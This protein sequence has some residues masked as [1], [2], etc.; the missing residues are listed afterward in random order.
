MLHLSWSISIIQCWVISIGNILSFILLGKHHF[1]IVLVLCFAKIHHFKFKVSQNHTDSGESCF[2]FLCRFAY[3]SLII[4]HS[5]KMFSAANE[6]RRFQDVF[7][8]CDDKVN[9]SQHMFDHHNKKEAYGTHS[10]NHLCKSAGSIIAV[11]VWSCVKN[12]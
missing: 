5:E 6:S 11:V 10:H 9:Y 7:I 12:T 4:L 2:S 1:G 3:L 8:F